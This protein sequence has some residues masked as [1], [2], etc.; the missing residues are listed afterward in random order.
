MSCFGFQ[1]LFVV[2]FIMHLDEKAIT[3]SRRKELLELFKTCFICYSSESLSVG[4]G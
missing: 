3:Y 2:A 1:I 4:T